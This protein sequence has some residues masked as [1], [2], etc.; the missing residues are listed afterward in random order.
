[1]TA[2]ANLTDS[3]SND[4]VRVNANGVFIRPDGQWAYNMSTNS[5]V[6]WNNKEVLNNLIAQ[7]IRLENLPGWW[8]I[9]KL[10]AILSMLI[11]TLVVSLPPFR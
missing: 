6:P 4:T 1:M 8:D 5:T 3:S 10:I 9:F 2:L 7:W 11:L